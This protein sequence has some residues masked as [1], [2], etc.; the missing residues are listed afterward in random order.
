MLYVKSRG[1]ATRV[2]TIKMADK[3]GH[4]KIVD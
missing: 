3:H 1:S 4:H 2:S